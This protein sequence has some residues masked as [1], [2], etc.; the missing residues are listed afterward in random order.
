MKV[1]TIDLED[2]FHI[3]DFDETES[4]TSWNLFGSRLELG[5][6]YILS[7]LSSNGYKATFFILGWIAEKY[8]AI[9]K[10]IISAGYE[11]GCHSYSHLLIY[12][13]SPAKVKSDLE[14]SVKLLEDITGNK[15]KYFRA[16]GFS[17]TKDS[18]WAFDILVELGFEV[19]SSIFPTKRGH[20][21][22]LDFPYST[23][24]NLD[25]KGSIIKELP[26]NIVKF[27]GKEIVFS[28]G[29][30][31]RLIPYFVQQHIYQKSE[32]VMTY[33][34]PRDFDYEQPVLNN[35]SLSRRFK[36]YVGLKGSMIKFNKL[37]NDFKFVDI[38]TAVSQI[39]WSSA[40]IVSL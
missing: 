26:I 12:K 13:H 31:F 14:Y 25:I 30:Y 21:G 32:Y 4:I 20:G 23:P 11:I 27:M 6:D 33:F 5:L 28:G 22:Y 36:S 9:V 29:G 40:P 16:P 10:Q 24:C 35:L 18:N 3:L 34:H 1:L 7:A 38:Q 8:P 19:D 17:I 39:D 15:I 2:W 37:L